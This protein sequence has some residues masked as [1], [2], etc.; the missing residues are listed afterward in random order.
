QLTAQN[1]INLTA[2]PAAKAAAQH[3]FANGV[4]IPGSFYQVSPLP[5][6]K[7]E[8]RS[9]S[10][11]ETDD[12]IVIKAATQLAEA[13]QEIEPDDTKMEEELYYIYTELSYLSNL[14]DDESLFYKPEKVIEIILNSN[15]PKIKDAL[16][17][18]TKRHADLENHRRAYN[19]LYTAF[20]RLQTKYRS[21]ARAFGKPEE[22]KIKNF[23]DLEEG[24]DRVVQK[25]RHLS[26]LPPAQGTKSQ[27]KEEAGKL[28][29][30]GEVRTLEDKIENAITKFRQSEN[31]QLAVTLG[32][33]EEKARKEK[34]EVVQQ[35][36]RKISD[37]LML[38]KVIIRDKAASQKIKINIEGLEEIPVSFGERK[39]LSAEEQLAAK[40]IELKNEGKIEILIPITAT[41]AALHFGIGKKYL[42]EAVNIYEL[43]KLRRLLSISIRVTAAGR[44]EARS[45]DDEAFKSYAKSTKGLLV[46]AIQNLLRLEGI[47]TRQEGI[48]RAFD[49][50]RQRLNIV[51]F[52]YF[53]EINNLT[54]EDAKEVLSELFKIQ[55]ELKA[56]PVAEESP[57]LIKKID[58]IKNTIVEVI[59]KTND[60]LDDKKIQWP[61]PREKSGVPAPPEPEVTAE[62]S[63]APQALAKQINEQY[64]RLREL[65]LDRLEIT[66]AYLDRQKLASRQEGSL[67]PADMDDLQ[68][69]EI[70][71]INLVFN[72]QI[73]IFTEDIGA[74][75]A[76]WI[77]ENKNKE[78][79]RAFRVLT[80]IEES[81][82]YL[83][84]VDR[85]APV[86]TPEPD[87]LK[88]EF[89]R[90]TRPTFQ[91]KLW[92]AW[93]SFYGEYLAPPYSYGLA[94][95]IIL[96]LLA[97]SGLIY[98][99]RQIFDRDIPPPPGNE[100]KLKEPAFQDAESQLRNEFKKLERVLEENNLE[101]LDRHDVIW[102][103]SRF[104]RGETSIRVTPDGKI[105][106]KKPGLPGQPGLP[107]F[108]PGSDYEAL[109]NLI[110]IQ[111]WFAEKELF[112]DADRPFSQDPLFSGMKRPQ[113]LFGALA[114]NNFDAQTVR[115]VELDT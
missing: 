59:K 53:R 51:R 8:L 14:A 43:E 67:S 10:S 25:L 98:L 77:R 66:V 44:S 22:F 2:N 76:E 36:Y 34:A 100:K 60:A 109:L 75:A 71:T 16:R 42:T 3:P 13:Y 6:P 103:A 39:G 102:L 114:R 85:P 88:E 62:L 80:L 20:Q 106:A 104:R 28:R 111:F 84:I 32:V 11:E 101:N 45:Q 81:Q 17:L 83:L 41:K 91:E 4:F 90:H 78:G 82:A 29:L 12:M 31:P 68:A 7:S 54:Y 63:E 15:L 70:K 5:A 26:L 49:E 30:E 57:D 99:A 87:S 23:A 89:E 86:Q 95:K 73:G 55:K 115:K 92:R 9:E 50:M 105:E 93:V 64:E 19:Q 33:L 65:P 1:M 107:P 79:N 61:A 52:Q 46:G 40:L 37:W 94:I 58:L 110:D 47:K 24:I 72:E 108:R 48:G 21:E 27:P 18:A 69:E 74:E 113:E 35:F 96:A 38:A 56:I 112:L 97:V